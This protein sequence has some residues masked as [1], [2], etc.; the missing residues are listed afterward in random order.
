MLR[1]FTEINGNLGALTLVSD[2]EKLCGVFFEGQR[3]FPEDTSN[4]KRSP[5]LK[6]LRLAEAQLNEYFHEGRQHFT[7]PCCPEGTPFQREVWQAITHTAYGATTTYSQLALAID[8][9]AAH[10]AVGTAV[11]RNPLSIIIPCHRILGTGGAL[12]GY[13][14]GLARKSALLKLENALGREPTKIPS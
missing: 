8:R 5:G 2:G 10:R 9:P 11:G 14:G 1:Y 7:L 6:V 12:S 3:Y 13:A 4:W